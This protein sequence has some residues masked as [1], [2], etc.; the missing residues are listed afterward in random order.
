MN[1]RNP[2]T[3]N[4]DLKADGMAHG[5]ATANCKTHGTTRG[6]AGRP[7]GPRATDS[8]P[9]G[10]CCGGGGAGRRH[11]GVLAPTRILAVRSY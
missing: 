10:M 2:E 6:A 3:Q 5:A 11:I 4:D 7:R 8:G 1:H 9:G